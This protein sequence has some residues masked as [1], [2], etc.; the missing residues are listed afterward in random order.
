LN[1]LFTTSQVSPTVRERVALAAAFVDA[2][3]RYWLTVFPRV[4]RWLGHWQDRAEQIPDPALRRMAFEALHK[5][6]NIEGATAFAAFAPRGHRAAVVRALAAFQA[7][8]GYAD[9]VSE[10]PH[11]QA[12]ANGQRLHEALLVALDPRA[13]HLDYY[14]HNPQQDDG[15]Y[16]KELVDTCRAALSTLPS[17]A[18]VAKSAQRAAA[19]IVTFQSLNVG[20]RSEIGPQGDHGA[21]ARWA[22]KETPAGVDLQWWET[23]ASAGSSLG[24]HVLI[25]AAADPCVQPVDI[26]AIEDAYFPWIGALHSLLDN[27]VDRQEDA[28]TDQ[29]NL[30]GYYASPA[31][32]AA[33]MRTLAVRAMRSARALPRGQRHAII[34]AAMAGNYLS[35][36]E[37]NA[38]GVRVI[39]QSV[40]EAIGYLETPTLLVFKLWRL[41]R[42][43]TDTPAEID[44][45]T[46][47]TVPADRWWS[48]QTHDTDTSRSSNLR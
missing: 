18:A 36:P 21:L 23:A 2:A 13:P 35:S 45:S 34:L 6:G 16:L 17:Y 41:A 31:Q 28:M 20:D 46:T 27:I 12:I 10:Q 37:A 19:R 48:T 26:A 9:M 32:A 4:S 11:V 8:Y 25:A 47:E 3:L 44:S 40:R 38:P 5:H 33:R 14:A 42:G 30:I 43:T 7:A 29:H 24:V 39:S 22:G 1:I 15:G